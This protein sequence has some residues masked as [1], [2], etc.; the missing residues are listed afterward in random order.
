MGACEPEPV[1]D[2]GWFTEP[3]RRA[4]LVHTKSFGAYLGDENVI[5][6]NINY[7]DVNNLS[8][9]AVTKKIFVKVINNNGA[10]VDNAIVEYQ[11][12]NY[13]EFYPLAVVPTNKYGISQFE[14]GLGDLL[15]WAHK[16][17]NFDFKKISVSETDTLVLKPDSKLHFGNSLDLDLDVPL[18]RTP[19]PGPSPE[20]IQQNSDRI[21]NENTI[22]QKYIDSWM[23]PLESKKLALR[24]KIDTARVINIIARSMG[25]Y[26]E[27]SS[28]LSDTPDSLLKTA[29][30]LLEILPDKDL[31][32][33]RRHILSDHLINSALAIKAKAKVEV[34]VE[35]DEK[36]FVEYVLNPRV[37]NEMLV[38]WRHYFLKELPIDLLSAGSYRSI[39][40]CQVP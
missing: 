8:K 36:I 39:A 1:L 9:Y 5:N 32:D 4:M 31:R 21:S 24:L 6:R 11:L 29:M 14:T 33:T 20:L 10:P 16:D 12:Y 25:N 17:D 28:F 19:L 18:V 2:R 13:A 22:R 27:I 35:N 3:A 30:S 40:N 38:A 15:V 34:K 26:Q 23:T 7:T 37:S